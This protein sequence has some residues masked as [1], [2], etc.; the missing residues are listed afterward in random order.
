MKN[1]NMK[2]PLS[3]SSLVAIAAFAV[4]ALYVACALIGWGIDWGIFLSKVAEIGRVSISGY[5]DK[6]IPVGSFS[7]VLY[8]LMLTVRNFTTEAFFGAITVAS[9]GLF[10]LYF[11]KE[12]SAQQ[13]PW[14]FTAGALALSFLQIKNIYYAYVNYNIYG[15]SIGTVISEIVNLFVALLGLFGAV[16]IILNCI[17]AV[18]NKIP[19]AVGGAGL[20]LSAVFNVY[21]A[22]L[23]IVKANALPFTTGAE[24]ATAISAWSVYITYFLYTVAATVFFALLLAYLVKKARTYLAEQRINEKNLKKRR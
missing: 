14:A 24:K 12:S 20:L 2:K 11:V 3:A 19:A 10:A 6:A 15:Q 18:K 8:L 13:K 4:S 7:G 5:G 9:I 1:K 17:G 21:T 16:M 23:N 22:I